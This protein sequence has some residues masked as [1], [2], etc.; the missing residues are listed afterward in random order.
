VASIGVSRLIGGSFWATGAMG[1]MVVLV[2]FLD[3]GL[4]GLPLLL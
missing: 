2:K 4:A 3:G 1:P